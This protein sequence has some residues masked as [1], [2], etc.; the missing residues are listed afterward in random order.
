MKSV[1]TVTLALLFAAA[2]QA[3]KEA[4]LPKDLPAYGP[5]PVFQVPDVKV[6]KLDNGLTVWLVPQPGIPRVAFRVVLLGG[7]AADPAGRPG[8]SE[9]LARTLNQGTKTRSA[10]QP[11]AIW[12]PLPTAIALSSLQRCFRQKLKQR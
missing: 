12:E 5:Q 9:L 8:L 10:R 4:P 7:L 3:Q 1:L 11:E 2:A 6:S